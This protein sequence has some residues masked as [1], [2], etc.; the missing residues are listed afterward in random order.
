MP[1]INIIIIIIIVVIVVIIVIIIIIIIIIIEFNFNT[2]T[3]IYMHHPIA[4]SHKQI[5]H[6]PT[7]NDPR[8]SG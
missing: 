6:L 7:G 2:T 5:I 1:I 3:D 4:S 8:P